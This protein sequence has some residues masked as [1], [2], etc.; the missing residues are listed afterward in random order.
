MLTIINNFPFNRAKCVRPSTRR[1]RD[2][3]LVLSP[4]YYSSCSMNPTPLI[5]NRQP[6]DLLSPVTYDWRLAEYAT[7]GVR[8]SSSHRPSMP[9]IANLHAGRRRRI[10]ALPSLRRIQVQPTVVVMLA[11]EFDIFIRP[12][13]LLLQNSRTLLIAM[14]WSDTRHPLFVARMS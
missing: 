10:T 12:S 14:R 9:F 5:V 13:G 1:L 2:L 4:W 7:A 6:P 8:S 3:H 11:V